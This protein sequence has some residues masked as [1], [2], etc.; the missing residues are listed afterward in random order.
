VGQLDSILVIAN[1][2]DHSRHLRQ[3]SEVLVLAY[4][5]RGVDTDKGQ[6]PR[7]REVRRRLELLADTTPNDPAKKSQF[8]A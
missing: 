7:D 6:L 3:S 1:R 8:I 5:A 2:F 4:T